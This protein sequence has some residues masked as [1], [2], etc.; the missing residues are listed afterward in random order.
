MKRSKGVGRYFKRNGSPYYWIQYGY[1][2]QDIREST[3]STNPDDARRLLR[4]RIQEME[5]GRLKPNADLLTFDDLAKAIRTHYAIKKH[6]SADRLETSLNALR[7]YFALVRAT[8]IPERL[9]EYVMARRKAGAADGT[10]RLELRALEKAFD[11]AK[12]K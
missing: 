11:L 4:T 9:P 8:R 1:E 5:Q 6:R 3:K 7:A 10:I 2:G 12:L